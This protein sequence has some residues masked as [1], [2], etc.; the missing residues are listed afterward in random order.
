ML[1]LNKFSFMRAEEVATYGKCDACGY[2][3][4]L[5]RERVWIWLPAC[6]EEA[7][8]GHIWICSDECRLI[9]L[10]LLHLGFQLERWLYAYG[11]I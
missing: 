9:I 6:K 7:P 11:P 10:F 4:K 3:D 5:S 1:V 8:V 2:H